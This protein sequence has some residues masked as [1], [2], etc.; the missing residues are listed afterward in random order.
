MVTLYAPG[1]SDGVT[2]DPDRIKRLTGFEFGTPGVNITDLPDHRSAYFAT[3]PD[4]TVPALKNLAT[5]AGVHLYT[6]LEQPVYANSRFLAVHTATGGIQNVR[7]PRNVAA[8]RELF[9][10]RLV[11]EN[12][13][14]FEFEFQSP[15]TALFQL[16]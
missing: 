8:V 5:Q 12:C 11:A 1:I 7:L 2:L 13:H 4:M 9:A 3:G 15:D 16:T 10:D 6:D 14:A